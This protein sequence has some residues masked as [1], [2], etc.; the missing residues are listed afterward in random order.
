MAV[1]RAEASGVIFDLMRSFSLSIKLIGFPSLAP[2]EKY[3][4]SAQEK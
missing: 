2:Q 4:L 1:I 3:S